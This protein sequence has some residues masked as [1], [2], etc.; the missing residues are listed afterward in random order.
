MKNLHRFK[1]IELIARL[2]SI[3]AAAEALSITSTALNRQLI[4]LEEELGQPL[5][6]RLPRGVRLNTAGEMFLPYARQQIKDFERLK[7]QLADLSGVRR[8]HIS[9]ATTRAAIPYFLPAQ[10]SSYLEQ[11]PLV[12]F[13]VNPCDIDTAQAQLASL[14]ADLALIFEPPLRREFQ[15][16]DSLDQ[17]IVAI[18]PKRHP[19]AEHTG[20]VRLSDCL[21]HP[22]ALPGSSTG[23]RRLLERAA[24]HTALSMAV[25]VESEDA[26]FLLNTA[27]S[28]NLVTFD[29]PLSLSKESLRQNGLTWR[30]LRK[31]DCESGRLYIGQ[32]ANRTLSIA[33]TKFT[34]QL[35]SA[36][37]HHASLCD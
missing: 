5:F 8:G 21:S 3:R 32:L 14:E 34:N 9:V 29:I 2:G 25:T 33:A 17:D 7:V 35:V 24:Q 26:Q 1:S 11:H 13:S 37:H 10:I 36:L 27:K 4:R 23:V 12:S 19:L 30:A 18:F 31:R 16:I 28:G 15:V 22:L 20:E 6:E